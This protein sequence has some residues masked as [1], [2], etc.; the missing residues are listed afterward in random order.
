MQNKQFGVFL[1]N[2]TSCSKATGGC[3]D[4]ERSWERFNSLLIMDGKYCEFN[5]FTQCEFI[6]LVESSLPCHAQYVLYVILQNG[7]IHS[8][9]S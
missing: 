6:P 2:L 8:I 1:M 3:P 4:E 5:V 7:S 9:S